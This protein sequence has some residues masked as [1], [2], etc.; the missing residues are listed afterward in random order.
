[1]PEKAA[2]FLNF[3]PRCSG[4]LERVSTAWHQ[5]VAFDRYRV[6]GHN[7]S[8]D[9]VC[10]D[11]AEDGQVVYLNH[12][13]R[14]ERVLMA[15]SVITLAECLIQVRDFIAEVGGILDP[16]A[17]ERI[18]PLVELLRG[19]DPIACADNGYWQQECRILQS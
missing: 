6:I 12:D 17:P 15:S 4:T 16:I 3:A 10:I 7:G 18:E 8:G 5:P 2:P 11:E 14:F 1:L 13:N 9:P 19:I